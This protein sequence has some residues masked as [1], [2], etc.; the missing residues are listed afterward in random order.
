MEE[1]MRI[2]HKNNQAWITRDLKAHLERLV[3]EALVVDV[4][5]E[6]NW[7]ITDSSI[8]NAVDD[9]LTYYDLTDRKEDEEFGEIV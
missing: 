4:D 7:I 5:D 9:I 6:G 8:K 3:S 1:T 2:I